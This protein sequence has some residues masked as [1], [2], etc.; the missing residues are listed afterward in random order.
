MILRRIAKHVRNQ[1]WTAIMI[2][3]LIVVV[4]V[5]LGIQAQE[6]NTA[7]ENKGIERQYLQSLHEQVSEM[8]GNNRSRVAAGQ[9]RLVELRE[10]AEYLNSADGNTQLA[11]HH[12]RAIAKSHIYVGRSFVP[13]AIEELISTGRLQL[14]NNNAIR[15]AIVS[16]SQTIE[17]YQQLNADIQV[18]RAVLSRL[19]PSVI[20]LDPQDDDLPECDFDAMRLS[21]AF[22]NDLADNGYRYRAYVNTVLIGQQELRVSLRKALNRELGVEHSDDFPE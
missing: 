13:P 22:R 17:G 15:S 7:R 3:L 8:I 4:G 12:C 10:V 5:Y 2:D 20:A 19:Y 9:E 11:E 14:I 6:W 16:Y 18:D 21:P 1:E